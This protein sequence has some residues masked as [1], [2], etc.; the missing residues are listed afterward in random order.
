MSLAARRV[1]VSSRIRLA[2]TPWVPRSHAA[3]ATSVRV[4]PVPAPASTSSGP[5]SCVTA[6]RCCS[7]SPSRTA[8]SIEHAYE[9][10]QP[11]PADPY[12]APAARAGGGRASES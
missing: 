8:P 6:R 4:F 12:A 3:R 9:H 2:G 10:N 5:A 7:F 11:G 1:K